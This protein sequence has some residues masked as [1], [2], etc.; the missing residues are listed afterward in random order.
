MLDAVICFLYSIDELKIYF[1]Q[2]FQ[3]FRTIITTKTGQNITTMKTYDK[4]FSELLTKI[5]PNNS[6]NKDYYNQT[7][8][9]D[10]EKGQK[11]FIEKHLKGNIIQKMFLIPK[12]EKIIVVSVI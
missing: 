3:S 11:I 7:Q 12:E 4:I 10:E 1:S 8:Q 9:Y 6:I 5:D 2:D